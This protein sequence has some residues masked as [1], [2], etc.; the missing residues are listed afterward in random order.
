MIPKK[1]K[2]QVKWNKKEKDFMIY[3]PRSADGHYIH[4][5][6]LSKVLVSRSKSDNIEKE[7][8]NYTFHDQANWNKNFNLYHFDWIKELGERGYDLTT[9]KFEITISKNKL[10]DSFEHL[11]DDLTNKE[12]KEVIRLGFIPPKTKKKRRT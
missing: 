3:Y 12:Q 11:W 4:N 5:Y 9:L 2:L 10:Q 8:K 7:N 6:L 1:L